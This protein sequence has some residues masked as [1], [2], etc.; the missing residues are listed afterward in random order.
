MGMTVLLSNLLMSRVC[1]VADE[2]YP[3]ILPTEAA[4][5]ESEWSE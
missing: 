3:I 4:A 1:I 2:L 5:T